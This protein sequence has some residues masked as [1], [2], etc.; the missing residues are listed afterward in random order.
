MR[1]LIF[2]SKGARL[3]VLGLFVATG[4]QA[5]ATERDDLPKINSAQTRDGKG[6][7]SGRSDSG[8]DY[9]HAHLAKADDANYGFSEHIPIKVGPR[10]KDLPHILY[11]NSLRGPNGEPIEWERIGACCDFEIKDA[12]LGGVLDIYRLRIAGPY[13]DLYLFVDMYNTAPL[14]LPSGFTQRN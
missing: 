4:G 10:H 2:L 1:K 6:V 5:I 7:P 3:L 8:E 12:P 11:L 14:E 9:I 13:R